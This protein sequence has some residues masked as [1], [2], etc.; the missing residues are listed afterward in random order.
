MATERP[1][2]RPYSRDRLRFEA[3]ERRDLMAR[4][5]LVAPGGLA[6]I[7]QAVDK[8]DALVQSFAQV[9]S[10][11]RRFV[12]VNANAGETIV[13]SALAV[14]NYSVVGADADTTTDTFSLAGGATANSM[15]PDITTDAAGGSGNGGELGGLV[16]LRIVPEGNEKAG[17][18]VDIRITATP[19]MTFDR[20]S[21]QL[22]GELKVR[23]SNGPAVFQTIVEQSRT[24]QQG[25]D[26]GSART[27]EFRSI[28]G[29]TVSVALL[30]RATSVADGMVNVSAGLTATLSVVAPEPPPPPPAPSLPYQL[31]DPSIVVPTAV[32]GRLAAVAEAFR[33]ARNKTLVVVA[34]FQTPAQQAQAL[35]ARLDSGGAK[36]AQRAFG[37]SRNVR[38]AIA[39][40]KAAAN[41][42]DRLAALTRTIEAQVARRQYLAQSLR[43]NGVDVSA[44][45]LSNKDVQ[46]LR[47]LVGQQK[48]R[49]TDGRR[50]AAGPRLGLSF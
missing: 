26:D 28:I 44:Q 10:G 22:T 24:G 9:P 42:A 2:T 41:P 25:P 48:G 39:A 34:G 40:W 1:R 12:N 31:A 19:R 16:G 37:N 35:M 14:A 27:V 7:G 47:K 33:V 38:D 32:A 50:S 4:F 15:A 36:A 46:A 11:E 21:A 6:L 20:A 23:Y 18:P 17:D 43:G 49:L 13:G 3:L 8:R 29:Q 5:E 30:T 45:G